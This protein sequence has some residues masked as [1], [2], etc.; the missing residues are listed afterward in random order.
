MMKQSDMKREVHNAVREY[1]DQLIAERHAP[2]RG[3]ALSAQ[4]LMVA[5]KS[6]GHK[7]NDFLFTLIY[8]FHF[9]MGVSVLK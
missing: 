7:G 5:A 4:D 9:Q 6:A 2:G 1:V 8:S 3:M